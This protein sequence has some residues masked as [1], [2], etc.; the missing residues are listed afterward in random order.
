MTLLYRAAV[1]ERGSEIDRE[2]ESERERERERQQQRHHAEATV[3]G[4]TGRRDAGRVTGHWAR[5]SVGG[6]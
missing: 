5:G 4:W 1:G 2:S 3:Y 6:L